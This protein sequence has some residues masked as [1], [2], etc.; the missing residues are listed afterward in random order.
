MGIGLFLGD[1][2]HGGSIKEMRNFVDGCYG[3]TTRKLFRL[4]Y[5]LNP[6]QSLSDNRDIR[7]TRTYITNFALKKLQRLK[8]RVYFLI[9]FLMQ[10]TQPIW[11]AL[12]LPSAAGFI[13]ISG[14]FGFVKSV[15]SL[16]WRFACYKD[17]FYAYRRFMNTIIW[18]SDLVVIYL[19]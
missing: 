1:M 11:R 4:L 9:I 8:W 2:A 5:L 12:Q 14:G 3:W 6:F 10:D 18:S 17:T 19:F 15:Y 16:K 13:C 7:F